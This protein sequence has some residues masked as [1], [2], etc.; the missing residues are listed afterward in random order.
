MISINI[1]EYSYYLSCYY[2]EQF[3]TGFATSKE[4]KHFSSSWSVDIP[5][6]QVN[7]VLMDLTGL[8]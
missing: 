4:T 3:P 2:D 5:F 1:Y 6:N 7:H 8:V